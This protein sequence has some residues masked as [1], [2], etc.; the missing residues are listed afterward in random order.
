MVISY[1]SLKT[2]KNRNGQKAMFT[3]DI[4]KENPFFGRDK[5]TT[6]MKN[7]KAAVKGH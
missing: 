6:G 5:F 2:T 3:K 7:D 4:T 1:V